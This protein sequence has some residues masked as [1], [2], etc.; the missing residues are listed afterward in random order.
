MN[1]K[2]WLKSPILWAGIAVGVF[3][4][5]TVRRKVGV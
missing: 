1:I 4:V 3:L 5:P 2:G